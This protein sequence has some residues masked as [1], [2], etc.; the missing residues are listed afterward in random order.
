MTQMQNIQA[1]QPWALLHE[2]GEAKSRTMDRQN[3]AERAAAARRIEANLTRNRE[4]AFTDFALC[5]RPYF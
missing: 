3:E 5:S 2:R 4:K 1:R